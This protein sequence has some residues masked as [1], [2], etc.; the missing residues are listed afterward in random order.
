MDPNCIFCK[1]AAKQLPAR[2]AFENERLVAF[3]DIAPQAPTHLI[4][5]PRQHLA[6]TLA[7]E[8]AHRALVGELVERAAQ[9]AR[10][11]GFANDGYRLVFNTNPAAGQ[12]VFHLHLHLLG[13]RRFGWPPG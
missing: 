1:I 12:T 11:R 8:P 4:L 13:G 3:E 9:L 10:E 7:L 5:V 6:S 2:I